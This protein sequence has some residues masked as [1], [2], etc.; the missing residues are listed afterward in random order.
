M[1]ERH[2]E[3]QRVGTRIAPVEVE[4][5]IDA[6]NRGAR[7][8]GERDL[9]LELARRDRAGVQILMLEQRQVEVELQS[10][11]A[12]RRHLARTRHVRLR[13]VHT[14]LL[15]GRPM[16]L[17][18]VRTGSCHPRQTARDEHGRVAREGF[19]RVAIGVYAYAI[20]EA[21]AEELPQRHH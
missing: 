17:G 3:S 20:A 8:L 5:D 13:R 18:L 7:R 21:S 16:V 9:P 2:R 1:L 4:G 19:A 12:A 11:E 14:V 10:R 6:G 15:G